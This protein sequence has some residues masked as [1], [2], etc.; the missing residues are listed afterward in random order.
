MTEI[1]IIGERPG[2]LARY[3]DVTVELIDGGQGMALDEITVYGTAHHTLN[4]DGELILELQPTADGVPEGCYYRITVGSDEGGEVVRS[5]HVPASG[6]YNWADPEIQLYNPDAPAMVDINA[7]NHAELGVFDSHTQAAAITAAA[8]RQGVPEELLPTMLDQVEAVGLEHVVDRDGLVRNSSKM[9]SEAFVG[10]VILGMNLYS[11]TVKVTEHLYIGPTMPSAP[12]P[13]DAPNKLWIKTPGNLRSLA[14]FRLYP[15]GLINGKKTNGVGSEDPVDIRSLHTYLVDE[16]D[17]ES[18]YLPFEPAQVIGGA[19]QSI[20]EERILGPGFTLDNLSPSEGGLIGW[21]IDGYELPDGSLLI[22]YIPTNVAISD[23]AGNAYLMGVVL[24]HFQGDSDTINLSWPVSCRMRLIRDDERAP[25]T[26]DSAALPRIPTRSDYFNFKF[27]LDNHFSGWMNGV[28]YVEAVDNTHPVSTL[29]RIG[30]PV[31]QGSPG[32]DWAPC[33][34]A[35]VAWFGISAGDP[36]TGGLGAHYWTENKG[37]QPVSSQ[38][39]AAM[40]AVEAG[41]GGG[42]TEGEVEALITAAIA[43][44]IDEDDTRLE[45]ERTPTDDSVTVAK[46]TSAVRDR[47]GR[48]KETTSD[49]A[50]RTV[51]TLLADPVLQFEGAANTS[52]RI[53]SPIPFYGD[54]NGDLKVGISAPAGS[55]IVARVEHGLGTLASG[56]DYDRFTTI[57]STAATA[58][59]GVIAT[60]T[61]VTVGGVIH[62]GNTPGTVAITWAPNSNGGTGVYRG[63]RAQLF[64]RIGEE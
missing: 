19:I 6:V 22:G 20:G 43:G 23:E 40:N 10:L 34:F 52:Y 48:T 27:T 45:D 41:T 5:I 12:D 53:D 42:L 59:C 9:A 13:D 54:P 1:Q 15:D 17:P 36:I 60:P 37:W 3:A 51:N 33:Y 30:M 2:E 29:D 50:V 35:R 38:A 62:V 7:V 44:K 49:S 39:R 16:E 47:M 11:L 8:E 25:H 24:G 18:G 61:I 26:I 55:E 21:G 56:Q 31:H 28:K 4:A 58:T 57:L 14:D 63:T 32:Q 46:L 64:Y